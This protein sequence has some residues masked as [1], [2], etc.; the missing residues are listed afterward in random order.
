MKQEDLKGKTPDELVKM[1]T[2]LRREQMNL[3]FQK[4]AGQMENTARVRTVR[5]TIAR[6]KTYLTAAKAGTDPGRKKT[7]AAAA[8]KTPAT[9][10]KR[11]KKAA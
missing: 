6:V 9:P 1:L 4:G 8:P 7:K 3:R 11:G 5:R 10:T 2:D